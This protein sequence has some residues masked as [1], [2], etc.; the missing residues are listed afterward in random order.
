MDQS[1][2]GRFIA[3]MRRAQNLTQRQLADQLAINTGFINPNHNIYLDDVSGVYWQSGSVYLCAHNNYLF[4]STHVD[5]SVIAEGALSIMSQCCGNKVYTDSD[6]WYVH[7]L[8]GP[9][10]K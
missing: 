1:K 2:T 3:E 5:Q 6:T 7:R 9:R 10:T 8:D 4:K